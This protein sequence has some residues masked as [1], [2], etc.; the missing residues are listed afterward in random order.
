MVAEFR[1]SKARTL[2][3]TDET[4]SLPGTGRRAERIGDRTLLGFEFEVE[5]AAGARIREAMVEGALRTGAGAAVATL[6]ATAAGAAGA[7]RAWDGGDTGR[8]MPLSVKYTP[9]LS[10]ASRSNAAAAATG[11]G[12]GGASTPRPNPRREGRL[13]LGAGVHGVVGGARGGAA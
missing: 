12:T 3:L 10:C 1:D 13:E 5:G 6:D 7:G 8:A 4:F 2:T 11:T 9:A